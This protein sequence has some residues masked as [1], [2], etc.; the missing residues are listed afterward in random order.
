MT[1][2]FVF[3]IENI[4]P[5]DR[6]GR[7]PESEAQSDRDSGVGRRSG[8]G[9]ASWPSD[10]RRATTIGTDP[11]DSRSSASQAKIAS[12]GLVNELEIERA[13]AVE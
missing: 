10:P 13:R 2:S 9:S 3:L 1:L 11:L 8:G 7:R 12:R 6:S 5:Q 4:W